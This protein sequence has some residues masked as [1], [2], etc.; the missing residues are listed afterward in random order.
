MKNSKIRERK[1]RDIISIET[2]SGHIVKAR[3]LDIKGFN[4][5]DKLCFDLHRMFIF[6]SKDR[7]NSSAYL[8]KQSIESFFKFI[9][10]YNRLP[11]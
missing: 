5:D 7:V 10:E 8:L 4:L 6:N 3:Y 1:I 9:C 11:S 2:S